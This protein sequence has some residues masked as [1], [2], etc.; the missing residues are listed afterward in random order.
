MLA[1]A[2]LAGDPKGYRNVLGDDQ[3][4]IQAL[5]VIIAF[6]RSKLMP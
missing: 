3:V 4:L 2:G 6:W 5:R 1:L